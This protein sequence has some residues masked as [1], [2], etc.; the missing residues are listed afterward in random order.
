MHIHTLEYYLAM[1]KEKMS[2]LAAA[3]KGLEGVMLTELGRSEEQKHPVVSLT[4]GI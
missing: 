4:C 3:Q 1:K 2:P